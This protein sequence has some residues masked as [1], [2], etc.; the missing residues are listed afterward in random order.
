MIFCEVVLFDQI[1]QRIKPQE[2]S[3][4]G[5]RDHFDGNAQSANYLGCATSENGYIVV[6]YVSLGLIEEKR[7]VQYGYLFIVPFY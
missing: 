4:S 7:S 5:G 3:F 6:V 1:C 2:G